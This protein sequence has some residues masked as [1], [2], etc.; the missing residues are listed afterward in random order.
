MNQQEK[1]IRQLTE[2]Y[3][4]ERDLLTDLQKDI[5]D[6]YYKSTAHPFDR[7]DAIDQFRSNNVKYPDM[8]AAILV[9]AGSNMVPL[10]T[11]TDNVLSMNLSMQLNYLV[12]KEIAQ[13]SL[14]GL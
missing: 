13:Q 9:A 7:N 8:Y 12:A 10:S 11:L 1:I 2:M 4:R 5:V 3:A 14:R 6:T